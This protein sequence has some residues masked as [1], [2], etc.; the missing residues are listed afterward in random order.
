MGRNRSL[1]VRKV[2]G[3]NEEWCHLCQRTDDSGGPAYYESR[4]TESAVTLLYFVKC[5]VM[6]ATCLIKRFWR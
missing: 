2:K 3:S 4:H 6:V 1:L 5:V